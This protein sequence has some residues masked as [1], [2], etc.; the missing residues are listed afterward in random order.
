M[1]QLALRTT[2]S[3][4]IAAIIL[5]LIEDGHLPPG[6][7]IASVRAAAQEYG[8]SKNTVVEAYDRLVASGALEPRAGSGF[9]VAVPR[10]RG[11]EVRPAHVAAAIDHLSLLREQLDQHHSVRV[12]DGRPPPSWME[13][14]EL[15]RFLRP[16]AGLG[17]GEMEHGYGAP[18]GFAP[19]RERIA[20]LLIE[21]SIPA[22]SAEV[23]LTF[24][25]NH[26]LDLIVRHFLEPG[27]A[28]FV[29]SPGYYP[30]FGKLRLMGATLVPILR[31]AEGPDLDDFE[32]KA[33]QHRPKLFF[34]QALAHNPTGTSM[35]L[36][37]LHRLLQ[38]A[39]RHGMMV[40]EDDP[41]A[42][43]LPP[44]TPRLAALDHLDR[45]LYVGTFSKTLSAS[46][47]AGYIAGH[48]DVIRS[49]TDVK[50]LTVVNSSGYVERLIHDLMAEGHYRHHL[51]R[52]RDRVARASEAA[53]DNLGRLGLTG[54][55][56]PSGGYYLW[57][58]LPEGFDDMDLTRRAASAGIF[59]APSSIFTLD[60]VGYQPAIRV[61]VAYADDC[62]FLDFMRGELS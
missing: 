2:R 42:D 33:V 10:R 14:S 45:V 48:R 36:A 43:I 1:V 50:M 54:F 38:A 31:T 47:R 55:S 39:E 6:R 44:M 46:L 7:R 49:L 27:D 62:R 5:R 40:V 58:P 4:Q 12:G 9:Y 57:C 17:G 35:G 28:V 24:G 56:P 18:Q 37:S 32:A 60:R 41:F 61:N 3:E 23:L 25:A 8:V 21:R 13:G 11:V 22:T 16:R 26:G 52:L 20:H 34:T 19:L 29:D 53:S 15:R 59:M 30:L 51:R